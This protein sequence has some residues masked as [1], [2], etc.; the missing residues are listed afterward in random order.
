MYKPNR[1]QPPCCS[2]SSHKRATIRSIG[3]QANTSPDQLTAPLVGGTIIE[4]KLGDGIDVLRAE[5]RTVDALRCAAAN[6]DEAA[7]L[8]GDVLPVAVGVHDAKGRPS[9]A[10]NGVCSPHG[11]AMG[12]A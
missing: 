7:I 11:P 12:A 3:W 5:A 10:P 9:P 1:L 8:D 2:S 4:T 6:A